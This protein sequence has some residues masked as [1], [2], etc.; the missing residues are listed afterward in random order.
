MRGIFYKFGK[1]IG[2]RYCTYCRL[3]FRKKRPA[4]FAGAKYNYAC[5]YHS[6]FRDID[7]KT[8]R[9]MEHSKKTGSFVGLW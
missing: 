1:K 9:A 5:G 6:P 4:I 3:H 2:M 7:G 8:R